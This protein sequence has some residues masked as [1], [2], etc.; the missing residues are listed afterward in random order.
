[1]K[2]IFNLMLVI[3]LLSVSSQAQDKPRRLTKEEIIAKKWEF[4]IDK[5]ALSAVDAQKIQPVFNEYEQEIWSMMNK[6]RELFSRRKNP[7]GRNYEMVNEAFINFELFKANA[8]RNYY[9]KLKKLITAD[10]IHRIFEAER[11]YRQNLFQ[12]IPGKPKNLNPVL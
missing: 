9:L 4:I 12:K 10:V 2:K 11:F 5:A 8:Q 3:L 6:N 7:G 1:M